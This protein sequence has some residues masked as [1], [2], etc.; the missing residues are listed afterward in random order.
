MKRLPFGPHHCRCNRLIRWAL[1]YC[2]S[3]NAKLRKH[4]RI[5]GELPMYGTPVVA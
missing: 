4:G 5:T 2:F 3:C 1:A